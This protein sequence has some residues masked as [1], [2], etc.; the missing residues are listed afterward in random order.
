VERRHDA[1]SA[2]LAPPASEPA[3][4]LVGLEQRLRGEGAER[5]DRARRDE[6]DRLLEERAAGATSSG[7]GLRLFGGRQRRTLQM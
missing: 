6:A 5:D 1:H 3:D 2:R 4:R 7:S